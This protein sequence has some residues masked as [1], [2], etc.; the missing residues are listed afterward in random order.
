MR[1]IPDEDG[2]FGFNLKVKHQSFAYFY[3]IYVDDLAL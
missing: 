3:R 2:K 1:I